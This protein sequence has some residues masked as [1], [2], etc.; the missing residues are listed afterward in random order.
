MANK[1]VQN[2]IPVLMW[3]GYGQDIF[4]EGE[5]MMYS[6]LQNAYSHSSIYDAMKPNQPATDLYQ[7]VEGDFIHEDGQ[8]SQPYLGIELEWFDT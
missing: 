1:I 6:A 4:P 8:T 3:G 5:M 2:H 7:I